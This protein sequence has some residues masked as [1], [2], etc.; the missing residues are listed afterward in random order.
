MPDTKRDPAYFRAIEDICTAAK[1]LQATCPRPAAEDDDTP[2]EQAE[3]ARDHIACP[4]SFASN[5]LNMALSVW[6]RVRPLQGA[7]YFK[8]VQAMALDP[9]RKE[10]NG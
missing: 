8:Q 5:C 10:A 7:E 6:H 3:A 9:S 1:M 4:H 2:Y